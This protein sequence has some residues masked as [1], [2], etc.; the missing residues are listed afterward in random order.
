M[1]CAE[2]RHLR[3]LSQGEGSMLSV[4]MLGL[5]ILLAATGCSIRKQECGVLFDRLKGKGPVLLEPNNDTVASTKFFH[6]TWRTSAT[7]K[8]LVT[9]RGTPEA[10][11]VEREFLQPNRLKL[12]YPGQG[13]VYILDLHDGEWLVSGSEP[14]VTS[15]LEQVAGQRAKV[16]S[17][18]AER[19]TRQPG[20]AT[21]I[22]AGPALQTSPADRIP[23]AHVAPSELRGRLKPPTAAG[24]ATLVR[25][26]GR[27]YLHTVTFPGESFAVLADWY[28]DGA[29][30]AGRL[31][32]VNRRALSDRLRLGDTIAIPSSLMLNPE[33]LPEAVVP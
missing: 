1:L 17:A 3:V 18:A 16:M 22:N 31:A 21:P 11:S 7:V 23:V 10:I 19:P 26:D 27:T 8:H 12:F 14:M 32:A 15:E 28:T 20:G 13:Q 5:T 4:R 30:N 29:E 9:Q 24:M 2:A 25:Q 6:E 33:P